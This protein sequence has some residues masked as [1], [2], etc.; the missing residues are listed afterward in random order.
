[1]HGVKTRERLQ[2][3]DRPISSAAHRN[4]TFVTRAC[5]NAARSVNRGI[6]PIARE[7]SDLPVHAMRGVLFAQ[8]ENMEPET[9]RWSSQRGYTMLETLL[10]VAILGVVSAMAAMQ[11]G[12]SREQAAGDAAMRVVL[13]NMNQAREL[14][15]TQRKYMR[16]VF[17]APNLVQIYREDGVAVPPSTTVPTTVMSNGLMEGGVEYMTGLPNTPD[18]FGNAGWKDFKSVGTAQVDIK[19]APDGTLVDPD[20]KT[21]NGSVYLGI[22]GLTASRRAVTVL[23]STGRVRGFRWV[24][25]AWK[26]V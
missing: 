25:S 3:G 6:C 9:R 26:L 15:I 2:I 14:A 22:P 7:I 20:G 21:A 11:I 10:V 18:G 13:S 5:V 19:F 12:S 16:L 17:T 23:G 8:D 24:G 1:M 4:S